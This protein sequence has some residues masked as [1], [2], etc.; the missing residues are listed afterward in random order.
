M[1]NTKLAFGDHPIGH[2]KHLERQRG[3]AE[4]A[5]EQQGGLLTVQT[6]LM[7]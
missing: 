1:Q 4:R 3:M 5:K 7:L 6:G 2:L